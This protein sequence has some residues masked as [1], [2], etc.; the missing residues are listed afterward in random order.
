MKDVSQ[1]LDDLATR[2]ATNGAVVTF[3]SGKLRI[4]CEYIAERGKVYWRINGRTAKRAD[5]EIALERARAGKPI[6]TV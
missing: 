4:D 3:V 5:V 2:A 6:I 1:T